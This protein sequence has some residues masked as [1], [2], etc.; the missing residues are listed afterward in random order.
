MIA[1]AE[2]DVGEA[3]DEDDG[4]T[5]GS[6]GRSRAIDVAVSFPVEVGGAE[7]DAGIMEGFE[8]VGVGHGGVGV[9]EERVECWRR[10]G[11]GC[12]MNT[13]GGGMKVVVRRMSSEELL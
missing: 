1:P 12:G 6:G 3:V 5:I 7:L 10:G 11:G 9:A 13:A 8:L 4:A 2:G